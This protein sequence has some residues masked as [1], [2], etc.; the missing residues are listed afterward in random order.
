[1]DLSLCDL[2]TS[3][4]DCSGSPDAGYMKEEGILYPDSGSLVIDCLYQ[5]L[6][7]SVHSDRM[8]IWTL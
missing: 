4:G 8:N 5:K 6:V 7:S 2:K 3:L 1:M